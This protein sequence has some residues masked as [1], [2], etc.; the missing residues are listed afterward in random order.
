M[1]NSQWNHHCGEETGTPEKLDFLARPVIFINDDYRIVYLNRAGQEFCKREHAAGSRCYRVLY[2]RDNIC[3]Y[4]V[5]ITDWRS[6]GKRHTVKKR[7]ETGEAGTARSYLL[8]FTRYPG[9]DK[10]LIEMIDEQTD[11]IEKYSDNISMEN[12]AAVGVMISGIAHDLNNPLT[13]MELNLQN[14]IANIEGMESCDIL[15]RLNM[16]QKDLRRTARIT[17]DILSYTK[18][19]HLQLTQADLFHVVHRAR[20]GIEGLY[21]A[22]SSR[23]KW[24]L[25]SSGNSMFYFNPEKIERMFTNLFKNSIQALDYRAGHIRIHIIGK[26]EWC[27]I[28]VEDDAGGISRKKLKKIFNPFYSDSDSGNCRGGTGLG[29]SICY[30][31][32]KEHEG[33]IEARSEN[34]KTQFIINL[35]THLNTNE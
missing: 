28:E 12:L 30:S 21:P 16:I 8:E 5:R 4:C 2:G 20:A 23:V 1:I 17:G 7:I 22:L 32:V 11:C 34:N 31:I 15:K 35:P 9:D 10:S 19:E 3:P 29:L 13:G 18:S 24:N 33:T 26:E 14:L 25:S 27:R 6:N